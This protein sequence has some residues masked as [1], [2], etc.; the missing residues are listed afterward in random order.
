MTAPVDIRFLDDPAER[1]RAFAVFWRAMVG[2]PALGGARVEELVEPGRYLGAFERG[3]IVGGANSYTS[4]LVVPGGGRV[5]HAAVTH[6]GVLPTH[7]RR[8]IL[9]ALAAR[10]LDDIAR[11]G[12]VVASLRASEG[13][14][15]RRFGYGVATTSSTYRVRRRR[16]APHAAFDHGPVE[17][18]DSAASP[19]R[20]AAI[21]ERASW[22]GAVA[23]PPQWWR[24]RALFEAADPVTPYTVGHADGYARYRPLGTA[25]WFA[26]DERVV[27]VDDLVAHSDDGY[28]ALVGHLLGLDLVDVVELGPRPVDDPLGHLVDDPRSVAVVGTRDE[29]WLRLVDVEAALGA[30]RYAE[31]RPVVVEVADSVLERNAGR[32]IVGPDKAARTKAAPELSL[33]VAALSSLY[34]GGATWRQLV[35]AGRA[36]EREAG[37]AVRADA[38]FATGSQPFAGTNF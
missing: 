25:A 14:I 3:A 37:A 32:Y 12:E 36:V 34:L 19:D 11:R 26:S 35:R 1:E 33:D 22:T 27:K 13:A 9:T 8:G 21:Y 7:T 31:A 18:L 29:T 24:L 6:I 30:R 20:L 17:L 38:L 4:W 15:Y 28:R 5:A 2:L 23:R 16:A 10:Q